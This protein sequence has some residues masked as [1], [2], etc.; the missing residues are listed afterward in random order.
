MPYDLA[1][2]VCG[3]VGMI[4]KEDIICVI[5]PIR[6]CSKCSQKFRNNGLNDDEFE[7]IR[8][9]QTNPYGVVFKEV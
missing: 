7:L 1:C 4:Q 9:Q 8:E 3:F 2:V 6:L 5:H